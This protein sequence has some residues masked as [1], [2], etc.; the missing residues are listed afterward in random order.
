MSAATYNCT[1]DQGAD[2]YVTFVYKDS[3]GT[4]IDLT[5]YTAAMMVRDTYAN[6]T[7]V[8]SLTS[9]SGITITPLTGTL[10]VRATATQTAAIAAGSYVYDL[11]ITS[12]GSIKTRLVQ[13]KITVSPEVTR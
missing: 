13:G 1:I 8:L 7:T 3:A 11:E 12:A 9:S 4:A 2:W 5:G 10:Q 6:S